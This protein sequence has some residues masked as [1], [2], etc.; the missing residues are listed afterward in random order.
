MMKMKRQLCGLNV[1]TTGPPGDCSGHTN[2]GN[3]AVV[4]LGKKITFGAPAVVI[5]KEVLL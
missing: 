2:C 3:K 5:A 4:V 1:D